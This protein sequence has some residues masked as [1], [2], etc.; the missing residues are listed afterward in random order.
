MV[1]DIDI[2]MLY[3]LCLR[4]LLYFKHFWTVCAMPLFFFTIKTDHEH[5]ISVVIELHKAN[6]YWSIFFGI[7]A[8]AASELLGLYLFL[9]LSRSSGF[10]L[11]DIIFWW[12]TFRNREKWLGTNKL[13]IW[14]FKFW[15]ETFKM[16][17]TDNT[18]VAGFIYAGNSGSSGG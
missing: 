8:F 14:S 5:P 13:G 16:V 11:F 10:L 17:A 3:L 12:L 1:I 18:V 15:D 2:F 7:S 9:H 6:G 4:F